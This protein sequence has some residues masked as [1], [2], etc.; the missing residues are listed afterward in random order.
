MSAEL[1]DQLGLLFSRLSWPSPLVRERA[2]KAIAD[3]LVD[4]SLANP[5][6]QY[7]LS[8]LSE[9][10]L[11]SICFVG[12][13][14]IAR[15]SD[16]SQKRFDVVEIWN[17]LGAPSIVAWILLR[18]IDPT[19]PININDALLYSPLSD[20]EIKHK[21]YFQK[22]I[23]YYIPPIYSFWAKHIEDRAL[24]PFTSYWCSEWDQAVKRHTVALSDN[25]RYWMSHQGNKYT[26]ADT[27]MSEIYRS[28][29]I[30][31]LARMV[32]DGRVDWEVATSLAAEICPID[33]SL[34]H[35]RP[36]ARPTWWPNCNEDA[37][38]EL[39]T[40]MLVVWRQ[41]E[42]MW[43]HRKS[44]LSNKQILVSCDGFIGGKSEKS[45]YF[46]N[47]YGLFQRTEGIRTPDLQELAEMYQ[48]ST[49][50]LANT[51]HRSKLRFDG[52]MQSDDLT[53]C[54]HQISDWSI[55]SAIQSA[56]A[57]GA[58]SR[59]QRWRI[60]SLWLPSSCLL[61]SEIKFYCVEDGI[62]IRHENN[63]IGVCRD[64]TDGIKERQHY[65]LPSLSGQYLSIETDIIDA[66]A[67]K[68]KSGF[69]WLCVLTV[70]FRR[71]GNS[72]KYETFQEV[73]IFGASNG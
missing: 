6:Y 20:V 40:T 34:W 53:A 32:S 54:H 56:R 50:F 69:C 18:E 65:E 42:Q 31:T 19:F 70:Y 51:K 37:G 61:D 29:Y 60:G 44:L 28:A 41:V 10:K 58:V 26:P 52:V 11:E 33:L 71:D 16:Y 14:P 73:R 24:T 9:Q 48:E 7:L 12:I 55:V 13:L 59:W 15:V 67:D 25:M 23:K 5:V 35:V 63:V 30:R 66:Y 3:M 49:T 22:Y 4:P 64:W 8:W 62:T 17:R 68:T 2:A 39:D 57:S 47:I 27:K 38:E 21:E 43:Q 36:Q 46:L 45:V 1:S 72:T